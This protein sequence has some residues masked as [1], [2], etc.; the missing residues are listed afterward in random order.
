MATAQNSNNTRLDNTA[1]KTYTA[2]RYGNDHGGISFGHISHVGDVISD[3]LLQGSDGTH[4]MAMDKDGP[5]K[6]WTTI[7]APGNF[8]VRCGYGPDKTKEQATIMI[9]A[10][11]GDIN[12]VA[13][14]GKIRMEADDIELIARGEK[15]S[16]GNVRIHATE[17]IELNA[18]KILHNSSFIK[19]ASTGNVEIAANSC[20]KTYGSM[21]QGVTDAVAT[22][23]SKVGGKNYQSQ[24]ILNS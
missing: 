22:K 12:I 17:V 10:D 9:A 7:A 4:F 8:Q 21:I 6:G 14:N 13:V 2:I 23:D 19:I 20:L 11:N 18:K 16:E 24:Q 3:V 5:R 1:K 15:T